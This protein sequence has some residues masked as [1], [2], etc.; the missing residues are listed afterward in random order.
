MKDV[1][2]KSRETLPSLD[3]LTVA[4][5]GALIE[6][7]DKLRDSKME[8]ARS[9]FLSEMRSKAAELGIDLDARSSRGG[10]RKRSDAGVKLKPKY[11][12]PNGETYT[13]RGPTPQWLKALEAKGQKREKYLVGE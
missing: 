7:A 6:R 10:R 2:S 11:Q 4:E 12:G 8:E 9:T 5:L 13:G 1:R 3:N